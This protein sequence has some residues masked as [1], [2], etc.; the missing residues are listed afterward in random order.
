L[1]LPNS[2]LYSRP[3]FFD[4]QRSFTNTLP[5]RANSCSR[6]PNQGKF[7]PQTGAALIRD[8]QGGIIG[9]AGAS[10]GSGDEDEACCAHGIEK[11]GLKADVSA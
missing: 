5:Y 6:E 8:A 10:G 3:A 7:L 2:G 11:A 9:A 4:S 1:T